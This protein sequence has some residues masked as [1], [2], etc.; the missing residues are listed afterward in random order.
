ML[1]EASLDARLGVRFPASAFV[2]DK[3]GRMDT[4][5]IDENSA[6]VVFEHKRTS[7]ENVISQG[8]SYLDRALRSL[9]TC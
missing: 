8:L 7:N 3:R 9:S 2:T 6:P 1:F 4:L 5:G